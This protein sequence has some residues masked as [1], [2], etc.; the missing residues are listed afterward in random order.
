MFVKKKCASV[1][2]CCKCVREKKKS[3]KLENLIKKYEIKSFRM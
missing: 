2:T 1:H 3:R